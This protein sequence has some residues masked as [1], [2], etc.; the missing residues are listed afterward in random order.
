MKRVLKYNMK[1][2]VGTKNAETSASDNPI[3][4][5]FGE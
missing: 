1:A 3:S 2:M 5:L 4:V